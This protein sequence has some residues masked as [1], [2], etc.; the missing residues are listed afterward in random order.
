ME[1]DKT[2][3]NPGMHKSFLS[4]SFT[5]TEQEILRKLR[6]EWYLTN[7]G[8]N[9]QL[10]Y[11]TDLRYFLMKPTTIYQ[12]MFN[13]EREI[14]C[15]FS[16]YPNF[17]PRTLDA[18][19]YGASK[20]PA[21]RV[22]NVC[23]VLISNDPFT[24]R[25]VNDMLKNDPEQP[26]V[27]PFTYD[28]LSNPYDDYFLR[29]R[30]RKHFYSRDLF[31]FLSPLRTDLYFFGRTQLIQDIVNRHR[32]SENSGLFG[33]R[34]SGKTSIIYGIE[35]FLKSHNGQ[36]VSIDCENPSI[37]KLRWNELLFRLV[38]MI[39]DVKG[40]NYRISS[41]E[42]FKEKNAANRFESDL[43]GLY[44]SKDHVP[45]LLIFDEIERISPVTGSSSHW[46]D[47]EDFVYF[48]QTLRYFFQKFPSVFSYLL[49]G[50]NSHCVETPKFGHHDNPLFSSI[51]FQYVP[52][53][54]VE[55]TRD[56][57]RKL[58]RYMGIK[59]DEI[60]YGKLTDDFG[61]HPFLIRQ[62]CSS[63]NK[64]S[65][66][67]RPIQVDKALYLKAKKQF[68]LDSQHYLVHLGGNG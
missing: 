56:M 68:F 4:R 35:R 15:V 33:L 55:K 37:H 38:E 12:E 18:F 65:P 7:S 43:L 54:D 25:K 36:F 61:G 60:I 67:D 19:D 24:E 20:F 63:I 47:E 17:E 66:G 31:S 6:N 9:V 52:P 50:T 40:S 49:V 11:S 22:D 8:E 58:G 59:F 23:R 39:K 34:K 27:V 10:G 5:R 29:N 51:P 64:I 53:F 3:T 32:S 45:M 26:I 28:E 13:L 21:L 46:R 44:E 1:I 16:P 42:Q 30:F 62:M 14:V 57:V 48:W 41:I 2:K